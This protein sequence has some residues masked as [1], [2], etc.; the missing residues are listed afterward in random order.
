MAVVT[1][2]M[3]SPLFDRLVGSETHSLVPEPEA[4]EATEPGFVH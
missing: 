3:A 2:L 4:E 1:T